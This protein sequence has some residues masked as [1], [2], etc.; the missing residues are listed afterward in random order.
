MRKT[1]LT[2]KKKVLSLALAFA[3][4][5]PVVSSTGLTANAYDGEDF[6]A[7]HSYITLPLNQKV[8]GSIT[9]EYGSAWY[10]FD[11]LPTADAWY[12]VEVKGT[13]LSYAYC[14]VYDYDGAKLERFYNDSKTFRFE[15]SKTY[16]IQVFDDWNS[17]GNFTLTVTS[18]L[19]ESDDMSRAT[20][21]SG[22]Y[23]GEIT[24]S[25][26]IDWLAVNSGA[27]TALTATLK[28]IS[29]ETKYLQFYKADGTTIGD[30]LYASLGDAN[31]RTVIVNPN[32][33]YYIK[34]HTSSW[35]N[36][37]YKV[38][39]SGRKDEPN[40]RNK[41]SKIK[42][43]K[44]QAGIIDAEGDEDWF[45]IKLNRTKN[46]KFVFKNVSSDGLTFEVY[47]GSRKVDSQYVSRASNGILKLKLRKGTYT[48]KVSGYTGN[49][50][51]KVK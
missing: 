2:I 3:V 38:T 16:Y 29:G 18:N 25:E 46:W 21:F 47:K 8:S 5:I 43:K 6:F 37:K 35:G 15:A 11:T 50:G 34:V 4:A 44:N 31:S 39:M 22:E 9:K 20:P 48:V 17:K 32:T 1:L 24:T 40:K 45:K 49:Y 51:V 42:L 33:T 30:S 23:T 12:T 7:N 19:D 26:D 27:N 14:N 10:K 28:N 41:A 13:S 36:G